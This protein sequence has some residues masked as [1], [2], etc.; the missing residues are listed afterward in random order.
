VTDVIEVGNGFDAALT[1]QLEFV[2]RLERDGEQWRSGILHVPARAPGESVTVPLPCAPGDADGEWWLTVEACLAHDTAW[3]SAGHIIASGQGRLDAGTPQALPE[4][5]PAHAWTAT[6]VECTIPVQ[7][8]RLRVGDALFDAATGRLLRYGSI[9]LNGPDLDLWRAPTE[10]DRG[11]GGRNDLAAVW[12]RTGLDDLVTTT[13]SV[14]RKGI[15]LTVT[16]RVAPASQ[17]FGLLY[18]FGWRVESDGIELS[19]DVAFDG[20]WSE[21]PYGRHDVVPPRLGL[22]FRLPG[23]YR[24]ATWFG[25]GP[26]ESYVDSCASA[27]VGRFAAEIDELQ[28]AYPYPQENGNHLDT[29]VLELTGDGCPALRVAGDP[30]FAFTARRWSSKA[31]AEAE[32]PT[33]LV[34][35]GR[36][37][38][39]L[40]HAQ[41]GLGSASCGPAL[42]ERY[43]IPLEPASWRLRFSLSAPASSVPVLPSGPA[44]PAPPRSAGR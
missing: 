42:P 24:S 11:Q 34:D 38:L 27:A 25:R 22:L 19:V 15:E 41:Q 9:E 29:R 30:T 39:N 44:L 35:S 26:H 12:Q 31:L 18:R 37:W 5:V 10:N 7:G 43:R 6:Q 4:P 14:I 21:T 1:E 23:E 17:P 40:D 8:E 13:R 32:H 16:G 36:I 33:D 28:T 2:W 3:A 20:P